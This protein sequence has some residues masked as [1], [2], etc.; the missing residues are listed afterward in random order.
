M[1]QLLI[2]AK[3]NSLQ[4]IATEQHHEAWLPFVEGR[5]GRFLDVGAAS[6]RDANWFADRGWKV[7]AV[8]ANPQWGRLFK[9]HSH[10]EWIQDSLPNLLSLISKPQYDVILVSNLWTGLNRVEQQQSL[11]RLYGLLEHK[12]LLVIT[13]SEGGDYSVAHSIDNLPLRRALVVEG[14]DPIDPD[15]VMYTAIFGANQSL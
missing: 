11:L 8:E 10:V 9:G 15:A 13:W 14:P 12:G 4:S 3:H 5:E 7:T 1:E 2:K 6:G